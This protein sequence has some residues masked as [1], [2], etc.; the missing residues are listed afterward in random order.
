M[1]RKYNWT[2]SIIVQ[3]DG[4]HLFEYVDLE[5][6][7]L[8]QVFDPKIRYIIFYYEQGSKTAL[9]KELAHSNSFGVN[10]FT[11]ISK[12]QLVD[13]YAEGTLI[14]FFTDFVNKGSESTHHIV[15][16]WGHGAGLGFLAGTWTT[17]IR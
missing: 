8:D 17:P 6:S 9:I 2:V 7:I 12:R 3:Q 10:H 4:E 11:V 1:S 5:Q 14:S 15:I 16:T 13:I